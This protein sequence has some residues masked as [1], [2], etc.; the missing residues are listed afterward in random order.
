MYILGI[1]ST[2]LKINKLHKKHRY[3]LYKFTMHLLE[4]STIFFVDDKTSKLQRELL[5]HHFRLKHIP[6][7]AIMKLAKKGV[8]PKYF[9]SCQLL[10]C[11]SWVE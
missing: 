7:S 10:S 4:V 9:L 8:N 6:F 3:W 5:D 2:I 1:S 11:I